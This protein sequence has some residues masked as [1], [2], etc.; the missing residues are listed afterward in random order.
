MWNQRAKDKRV[1][2]RACN[3]ITPACLSLDKI[4]KLAATPLVWQPE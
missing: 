2:S 1:K 4:L 3:F